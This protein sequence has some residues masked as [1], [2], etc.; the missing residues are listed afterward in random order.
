MF[1]CFC[2]GKL[3]HK[4][5]NCSLKV[6]DPRRDYVQTSLKANEIDEVGQ[7]ES[8]YGP[9]MVVTRKKGLARMGKASGSAKSNTPSQVSSKGNPDFS[10]SLAHVQASDNLGKSDQSD[11]ADT[12][13]ET[14]RDEAAQIPQ[15][16]IAMKKDCVMEDHCENTRDEGLQDPRHILGNKRKAIAKNKSKGSDGL[17]IRNSKN[18]KSHKRLS[19][20]AEGQRELILLSREFG[21]GK[22]VENGEDVHRASFSAKDRMGHLVQ[23]SSGGDPRGN[24]SSNKSSANRNA[25]MVRGRAGSGLETNISHNPREHQ[26]GE[27]SFRAQG[28]DSHAQSVVEIY[29]GRSRDFLESG[30]GSEQ[31]KEA[32]RCAPLGRIRVDHSREEASGFQRDGYG[33]HGGITQL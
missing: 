3:G 23:E 1:L 29:H 32:I 7:P 22:H 30:G 2:C 14:T 8:N 4:K 17:G 26:T 25:G 13:S 27:S 11:S 15:S 33:S 18:S 19:H 21:N 10:Q 24:N 5:D 16:D 31:A 6:K 20:S 9:W 28:M 12:G